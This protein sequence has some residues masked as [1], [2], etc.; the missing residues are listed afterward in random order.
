MTLSSAAG[1]QQR[2]GSG[3]GFVLEGSKLLA[4]AA[5]NGEK[6]QLDE[7]VRLY[8]GWHGDHPQEE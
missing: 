7:D 2:L 6:I 5:G 3:L 1:S 8:S 4:A